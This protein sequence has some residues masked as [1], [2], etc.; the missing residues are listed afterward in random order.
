M[1]LA[2]CTAERSILAE[3]IAYGKKI[4]MELDKFYAKKFQYNQVALYKIILN[5]LL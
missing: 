2:R 3:G 4:W 5:L 1:D